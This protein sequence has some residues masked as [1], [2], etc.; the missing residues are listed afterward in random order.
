MQKVIALIKK[1]LTVDWR[2]QNPISGILLYLASTIFTSFMAFK[3]FIS[4]EVWNALFWT[5]ILF[6]AITAISKSF[7][8]EERRSLYYFFLVKPNDL[9]ISKLI[10]SF[11]Y[12]MA[13][14]FLSLAIFSVLFGNPITNY[15]LFTF[16]LLLGCLGLSSAFTMISAIAFKASNRSIM[17]AVLGFPV[18]IPV[19]VL[20]ISNSAK[21]LDHTIWSQIQGNMLTLISVDVIIIA[22]TFVLF[23]FIW[24]S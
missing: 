13:L 1:D 16:N 4:I 19:L 15:L 6:T 23:P 14:S 7:V 2:Q 12:L 18:I 22:L 11:L 3:G 8:Q 20:T 10:Y 24:R 5:I 21:I 9:V 17:M